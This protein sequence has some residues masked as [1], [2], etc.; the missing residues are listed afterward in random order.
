MKKSLLA[1]AV[2]GT[3]AG[4]ASAQSSVN[5][6]G[7]VDIN[8]RY[9]KS[10][11]TGRNPTLSTDGANSSQLGF[12]G[13]EDIGGGLKAGFVLLSGLTP[14]TGGNIEATRFFNRRS[15]ISLMGS[16][17]EVRL[18][19][20]W[21]PSFWTNN[22][23]DAFGT[24]GLGASTN[25]R[26]L[27]NFGS[28][29]VEGKALPSP[30]IYNFVRANNS[31]GYFLPSNIG[32]VYGQLMVAAA[33]KGSNVA[34]TT[35]P[36]AGRYAGFRLGFAAGPFDIAAAYGQQQVFAIDAATGGQ[37][38]PNQKEFNIGTSF[39]AGFAKFMGYYDRTTAWNKDVEYRVSLGSVIPVGSG[40]IRLSG[41]IGEV[42]RY[43]DNSKNKV[44]Q[45]ALG[46][47]YNLSKRTAVYTTASTLKNG[48]A[49]SMVLTGGLSKDAQLNGR[50]NGVEVGVRHFF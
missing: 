5:L 18:G 6:Y 9:V 27:N 23:F 22:L 41:N 7:T 19:R 29:D 43:A 8:A 34:T 38:K 14:D 21:T 33:E 37:I 39:N 24:Q 4:V 13:T 1:L 10:T 15:T 44:N 30:V 48:K 16:F 28:L 11:G 12:K 50:S 3:F 26:Q 40:E 42:K 46:Y 17:G 31:I 32:G 45:L 47:L 49:S 25:I 20:D 35:A 36:V 2:L